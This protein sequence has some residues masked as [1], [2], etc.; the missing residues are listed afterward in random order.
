MKKLLI[1]VIYRLSPNITIL[2]QMCS[3]I[4]SIQK[5][6][7]IWKSENRNI[8][9]SCILRQTLGYYPYSNHDI[10]FPPQSLS[11]FCFFITLWNQAGVFLS[12][13]Q[14]PAFSTRS[15]TC[16]VILSEER[17]NQYNQRNHISLSSNLNQ[18]L[19][20][21]KEKKRTGGGRYNDLH[22]YYFCLS[23]LKEVSVQPGKEKLGWGQEA[24]KYSSY[25]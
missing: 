16:D 20:C 1:N 15:Q 2:V 6:S 25:I 10:Q 13:T 7:I 9:Y 17:L 5:T 14:M 23:E 4:R 18:S 8:H 21:G 24:W 12:E 22:Q 11:E 3:N 19:V